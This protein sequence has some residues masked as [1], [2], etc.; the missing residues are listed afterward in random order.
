MCYRLVDMINTLSKITEIPE[1]IP[2]GMEEVVEVLKKSTT[3]EE[4]LQ[5]TYEIMTT[6]YQENR[7]KMYTWL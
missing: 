3:Q 7:V 1:E 4:C 2:V 6:K 5:K